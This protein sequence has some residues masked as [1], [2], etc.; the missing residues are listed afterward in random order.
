MLLYCKTISI[1][2]VSQ[3]PA[4]SFLT[5]SKYFSNYIL[6]SNHLCLSISILNFSYFSHIPDRITPI[7]YW[8][9]TNKIHKVS[10]SY[11][12]IKYWQHCLSNIW[13]LSFSSF[14][15][16][17]DVITSMFILPYLI[18]TLLPILLLP[19]FCPRLD[20]SQIY[21]LLVCLVWIFLFGWLVW[22]GFLFGLVLVFGF[23][24]FLFA[25][26]LLLVFFNAL[27]CY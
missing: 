14:S 19:L 11:L 7:T 21:L 13:M 3:H 16:S 20:I 26:L 24:G 8:F 25:C 9:R 18:F 23:L 5:T 17:S 1:S 22:F 4:F 15:S 2:L 6:N 12:V 27:V 10:S